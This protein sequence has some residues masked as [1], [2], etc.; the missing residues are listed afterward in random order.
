MTAFQYFLLP[1]LFLCRLHSFYYILSFHSTQTVFFA[2]RVIQVIKRCYIF[3]KL[4]LIIS[5]FFWFL[6]W[7]L[8]SCR[9]C[10]SGINLCLLNLDGRPFKS[11]CPWLKGTPVQNIL[12]YMQDMIYKNNNNYYQRNWNIQGEKKHHIP[13]WNKMEEW[14]VRI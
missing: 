1:C 9:D 14:L 3:F 7:K 6:W 12:F 5:V 2:C 8:S 13:T 10:D 11:K 4:L